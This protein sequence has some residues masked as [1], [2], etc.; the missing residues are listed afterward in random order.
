M[1]THTWQP[2]TEP[3]LEVL[4]DKLRQD[5]YQDHSHRLWPNYSRDNF[6]DVTA[7]TI[8]WDDAGD[9]E[10]CSSIATKPVWSMGAYRIMNRT[11]KIKNKKTILRRVSDCVGYSVLSQIDWLKRNTDMRL[12]FISRQVEHDTDRWDNWVLDNFRTHFGVEMHTSPHR[13]LTCPNEHDDSCWQKIY[14]HG[15][16]SLLENWKCK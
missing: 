11:W 10:M 3:E 6:H 5:H 4:F 2:G 14:Y 9:P 12:C 7:M 8:H 16:G 13:F 15:D 1:K